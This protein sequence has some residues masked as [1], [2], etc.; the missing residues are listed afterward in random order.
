[1][2]LLVGPEASIPERLGDAVVAWERFEI[3]L[4]GLLWTAA[5]FRVHPDRGIGGRAVSL[6]FCGPRYVNA[7]HAW[8]ILGEQFFAAPGQEQTL[9][10]L[11]EAVHIILQRD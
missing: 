1:M 5:E 7:E 4:P 10:L 6:V 11:H 2:R 8:I 9:T 3:A